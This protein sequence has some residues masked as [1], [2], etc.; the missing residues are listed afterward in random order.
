MSMVVEPQDRNVAYN[1]K[2]NV[3]LVQPTTTRCKL[4]VY[5]IVVLGDGGVGKSGI[6]VRSTR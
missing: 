3:S 5:K 4:R 2:D 6:V 1:G